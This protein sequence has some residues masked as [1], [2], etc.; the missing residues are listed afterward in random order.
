L[1]ARD[2]SNIPDPRPYSTDPKHW[3]L[4]YIFAL[5]LYLVMRV[6]T[7]PIM[8]MIMLMV[9]MMMMMVVML[10][11]HLGIKLTDRVLRRP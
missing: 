5:V 6:S 11:R 9:V 8:F 7:A 2:F 10:C 3:I 1:G 4:L